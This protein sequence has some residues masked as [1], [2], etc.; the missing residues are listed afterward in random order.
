MGIIIFSDKEKA[1]TAA[2]R[3]AEMGT[4][5]VENLEALAEELGG[6]FTNYENYTEGSMGVDA[7]D[8]W[9]FAEDRAAGSFTKADE[10][11]TLTSTSSQ[12]VS[13]SYATVWLQGRP[14]IG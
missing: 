13:T 11:I 8:E 9:V 12:N 4:I 1:K 7:F 5:T 14:L 6:S 10:V 3:I 2:Q